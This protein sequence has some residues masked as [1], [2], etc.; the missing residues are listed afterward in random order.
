MDLRPALEHSTR[1]ESFQRKHRTGLLTLLFTDIVGSGKIKQAL[2]DH[3]GAT[4]IQQHHAVVRAILS[5]F[6]QGQEIDTAGDSFFL[7]FVNPSDAVRFALL[8]QAR[9]RAPAKLSAHPVLDRIGIHIGEVII[10]QAEGTARPQRL[11][12]AQVADALQA[13]H[14]A[15][16]IHRDVKPGNIL[17]E[18]PK[19][20][21][22]PT[23]APLPGGDLARACNVV[24]LLGG[25][26]GGLVH[27]KLTDF[28]IGQVV[29]EEAL[30][31]MTKA[32]FTQTIVADSS[33]SQTGSQMYMAP[34]L[35]AGKPA[36]T[37][38]DIYSLGVVLYQL[39]VGDFTR[40][41]TTD[42]ADHISDPLL[43]D[44]APSSRSPTDR[45]ADSPSAFPRMAP[46]WQWA[47]WT[48]AWTCG[49]SPAGDG[50]GP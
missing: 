25:V 33:S 42:W 24:P 48:V 35:L 29:S 4:S 37:R 23:P 38:S 9:L 49:M 8:L 45:C 27:A 3:A 44:A 26:R 17:V 15:G 34:E 5:Q 20:E 6:P 16:V 18:N 40:P 19:W 28:G 10:E 22:Q 32:G 47:G 13:A 2:G 41:L 31:G 12:G 11:F 39:L 1:V 21:S 14:D 43:G 36:S 50:F 46:A 7:M 30:K